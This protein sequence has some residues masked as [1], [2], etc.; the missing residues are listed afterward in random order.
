MHGKLQFRV[1]AVQALTYE[2]FPPSSWWRGCNAMHSAWN[3]LVLV[4]G[5]PSTGP[6]LNLKS[7]GWIAWFVRGYLAWNCQVR[8]CKENHRFYFPTAT[9]FLSKYVFWGQSMSFEDGWKGCT[10]FVF[11]GAKVWPSI[12]PRENCSGLSRI[13]FLN[14]NVLQLIWTA[15]KFMQSKKVSSIGF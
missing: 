2:S 3:V 15:T 14:R 10:W 7:F 11:F 9:C 13:F 6:F 1:T 8:T 5:S 4:P 12:W